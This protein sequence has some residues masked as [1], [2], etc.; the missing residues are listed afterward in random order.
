MKAER[1]I[2]FIELCRGVSY[3]LQIYEKYLIFMIEIVN[4]RTFPNPQCHQFYNSHN[5]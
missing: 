4:I 3:L 5:P 2:K 1:I